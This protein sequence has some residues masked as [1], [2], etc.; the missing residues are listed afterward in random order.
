VVSEEIT[1]VCFESWLKLRFVRGSMLND[2]GDVL[3]GAASSLHDTLGKYEV[4]EVFRW[5]QLSVQKKQQGHR[6]ASVPLVVDHS[7]VIEQTLMRWSTSQTK[8]SLRSA[9]L[10]LSL[11]G[12][13]IM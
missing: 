9:A 1:R 11:Q 10:P 7:E 6:L 12:A 8:A 3:Y 5:Q 4:V 13:L 2:E